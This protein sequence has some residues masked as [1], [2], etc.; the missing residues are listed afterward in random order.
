MPS[1]LVSE[2]ILDSNMYTSQHELL[3]QI[4]HYWATLLSV[5]LHHFQS[6]DCVLGAFS[7]PKEEKYLI[8]KTWD[9]ASHKRTVTDIMPPSGVDRYQCFRETWCYHCQGKNED[10]MFLLYSGDH[11]QTTKCSTQKTVI[12]I[13]SFVHN[14]FICTHS[15]LLNTHLFI[16]LYIT[17][18]SSLAYHKNEYP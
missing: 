12:F 13:I 14:N 8:N 7:Q 16:A 6:N 11:M 3:L 5:L 2:Y 4:L 17:C 10:I 1:P 9:W 15:I 18:H